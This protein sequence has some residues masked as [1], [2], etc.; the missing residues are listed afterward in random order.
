MNERDYQFTPFIERFNEYIVKID[1][2]LF[3]EIECYSWSEF[4]LP[5]KYACQGGKRIRPL[6]LNLAAETVLDSNIN[7][8]SANVAD[9]IFSVSSAVELLHTESVI[10][11]DIIDSDNLRRGQPSFHVKYG[12]NASILTADFILGIILNISAKANNSLVTQELSKASI[13][14]SEGEMLELRLVKNHSISQEQYINVI[15]NKTAS[16]F[17]ASAKMG[18]ILANGSENQINALANFGRLLGIAY[19][20]HDD[21]IDYN[22]EERLFN[23]LVKQNDENNIFIEIM[24]NTYLNYSD[25]ARKE[26]ERI[27]GSN[28]SKRI[29][30]ELTN[31]SSFS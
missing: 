27:E 24:E 10:H 15:E 2:S 8:T 31:L 20:I 3:K 14:M 9:N 29:L 28:R 16:L 13:R 19:Q 23:I 21:L 26:L 1:E 18:A 4:Y 7:S 11:D 5:L 30:Q 17:E 22:N 12:Y 6:I 25:L